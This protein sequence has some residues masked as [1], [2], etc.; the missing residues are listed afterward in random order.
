MGEIEKVGNL[1]YQNLG[2]KNGSRNISME[3]S[4]ISLVKISPFRM[5]KFEINEWTQYETFFQ[6][7][8]IKMFHFDIVSAKNLI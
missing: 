5:A 7:S 8:V 2:N 6:Q 1:K 4:H 3:K